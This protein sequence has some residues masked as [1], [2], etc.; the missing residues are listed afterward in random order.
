MKIQ[1]NASNYDGNLP[2]GRPG[3]DNNSHEFPL[4]LS[5]DNLN[6]NEPSKTTESKHEEDLPENIR[7]LKAYIKQIKERL[8][9]A[10]QELDE[11]K[12]RTFEDEEQKAAQIKQ[13]WS[14]VNSLNLE[15][16]NAAQSLQ[17]ALED[18]GITDPSVLVDVLV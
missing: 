9:M 2:L 14:V 16:M 5:L 4:R 13:Q 8:K 12:E 11:L 7:K 17:K 3:K 18:Q 6:K 15:L 10:K 1:G